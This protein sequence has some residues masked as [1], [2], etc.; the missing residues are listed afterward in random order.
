MGWAWGLMARVCSDG[1]GFHDGGGVSR[2]I[3]FGRFFGVGGMDYWGMGW[4]S[5]MEAGECGLETWRFIGKYLRM[6]HP[7][8]A[9]GMQGFS[10]VLL[11]RLLR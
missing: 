11:G 5:Y 8:I 9:I 10:S 3:G 6:D 1:N 2:G 4:C 7:T